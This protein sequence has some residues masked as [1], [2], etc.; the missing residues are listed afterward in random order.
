M[1]KRKDI[2]ATNSEPAQAKREFPLV[3][4]PSISPAM[5]E[6]VSEQIAE[7][8][9]ASEPIVAAAPA[10]IPEIEAPA[11]SS[12][13]TSQRLAFDARHKRHAL[14][15]V[16][17]AIAV[18]LGAVVG[19]VVSGGFAAPARTD[20]SGV[21][22]IN[23][24]QQSIAQ[25]SKEITALKMSVEAA[26]KSAHTQT[27][28]ISERFDRAASTE[29]TGSISA[30]QTAAP[31]PIPRPT[32]VQTQPPN[33]LPVVQDWSI[34][35]A[36]DGYIYVEGHGDVY[37]VVPGAPLPGLGAVESVKRQDGRW[38]VLT[39]KGMIVSMRDRRYFE[40]F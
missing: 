37:Q 30:L 32:T 15:A 36:R 4:S 8:A 25:L 24:M 3:D 34:R 18:A 11:T 14:L 40:S 20:V 19:V 9:P 7:L 35:D 27:A 39:P 22:K 38:V 33:R 17:M 2:E 16:S 23:A 5:P 29:I 26:N 1:T 12:P 6:P 21:Q 28:K 13:A 10:S 31:L